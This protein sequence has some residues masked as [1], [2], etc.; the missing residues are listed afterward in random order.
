MIKTLTP[1]LAALMISA[2]ADANVATMKW[3]KL[4]PLPPSA[5]QTKQPGVAG[6]FAGV[7]GDT[8][9]VAG[10]ANFPDKLPWEGGTK[11]WWDD[12]WVLENLSSKTPR[13]VS[14]ATLKLPRRLGYGISV[15]LPEGVVC[16]G[17][18]DVDRC[19]A[20]VFMLAW[21]AKARVLRPT[22]LPPMPEPLSF[23]AGALVGE[24]LYVAGGQT[25][26]KG[27]VPSKIFWALDLSKRRGPASEF[28]W[29]VLPSWPGP[30]RVLPVAAA[31]RGAKGPE[32]FLF[33]G[34][35]PEAGKPTAILSDAYA[36]DPQAKTWRT[37]PN[38]GAGT[39]G[40]S[41]AGTKGLSVMAGSAA[42]VGDSEILLFGGDRGELFLE[43]EKH[44]L[45]IAAARAA[46]RDQEV[47]AGLL[48][49]RKIYAA[50]PGFA[51]E[52]L[53]YDTKK[54][55]WRVA[56]MTPA[57]VAPQVTTL[58]VKHGGAILI[59]SG[60]IK[61]GIRTADVVRVVAEAK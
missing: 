46:G 45:A 60:E 12:V 23:M 5:G 24:T 6:P 7:H 16:V 50:H 8:L 26:M 15:D 10:G 34:R 9:I 17:G 30:A 2:C 20:E 41:S 44:D 14:D 57:T 59:P 3:D 32:F 4:P 37:L 54:N 28:K 58:A 11:I 38:I 53:A 39:S 61:P 36:F 47:E 22:E 51:R 25:T 33:S 1:Y 40:A 42:A 43:L 19:Y 56:G 27:A 48:A 18:H 49:K 21:D 55:T 52:V 29:Q 31:Q 35:T 13:W